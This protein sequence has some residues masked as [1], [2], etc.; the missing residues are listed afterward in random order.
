M[1]AVRG[2]R[3][4]TFVLA[5]TLAVAGAVPATAGAV[6]T[7]NLPSNLQLL[8]AAQASLHPSHLI[9]H[10]TLVDAAKHET[11]TGLLELGDQPAAAE[12]EATVKGVT[13][14]ARSVGGVEYDAAPGLGKV[15]K[16]RRWIT[17]P[18]QPLSGADA[19]QAGMLNSE[20][21]KSLVAEL[22]AASAVQEVGPVTIS[23][24]PATAFTLTE[25]AASAANTITVDLDATGQVV[26]EHLV[27]KNGTY[28]ITVST[29][30]PVTITAPPHSTTFALAKV[31]SRQRA[32][33]SNVLDE[34]NTAAEELF[35]SPFGV[36][37]ATS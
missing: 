22:A 14:G 26:G 20:I 8:L 25:P 31:P 12:L 32:T 30:T 7:A 19:D 17:R 10:S 16:G 29:T 33:V 2:V 35:S 34:D 36:G 11:I 1:P 27:E 28:T 9:A 5:A 37:T 13:I 4:T 3:P 24:G 23:G 18:A 6:A 15:I 21:V